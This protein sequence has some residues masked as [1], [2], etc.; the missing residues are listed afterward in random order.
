MKFL[1]IF[2]A[3]FSTCFGKVY[4]CFM[5]NHELEVLEIRF[6]EMAPY[7]DH[8]VIVEWDKA[9]RKGNL[10]PYYFEENK[11][12][13]ADFLDKV[14]HIK[15]DETIETENGW[16]RENW[17]RNQIMRGLQECNPEDIILISD[18]DEIIPGDFIPYLP[19]ALDQYR[20]VGFWQ[21][22]YQ[23]FLNRTTTYVWSG[24]FAVRY[25]D[26]LQTTPQDLRNMFRS[27]QHMARYPIGWHFSSM[28][29]YEVV[30][31]KY[32]SIVEGNDEWYTEEEWIDFV[33]THW[34]LVPIDQSYPKWVQENVDY[35]ISQKLIDV[36]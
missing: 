28:G 22:F 25:K 16:I 21:T 36:P 27:V 32:Y 4:D 12:K 6:H 2:L 26:L 33:R 30:K 8:F 1:L 31:E 13:Y 34:P 29:G 20:M 18:V 11:E 3:L 35:L 9:H 14:I 7:V 24:T 17:H 5:F 10:K 23:W 19:H 15:L